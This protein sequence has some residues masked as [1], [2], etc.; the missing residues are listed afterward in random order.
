MDTALVTCGYPPQSGLGA[1]RRLWT[2]MPLP[3]GAT[4][5][6][7]ACG[8]CHTA[9]ICEDGT[10]YWCINNL[11]NQLAEPE[12]TD[13]YSWTPAPLPAGATPTKLVCGNNHMAALC[14]D[15]T[16][17]VFGCNA[18]G[19]LGLGDT[20]RDTKRS[21][22]PAPLPAGAKPTHLAC[23]GE[24]TAALCEDGTLFVCG[25][26]YHGQLGLGDT[27]GRPSWTPTPLPVGAKPMQ[28]SCGG[29][30]TAALCEDGRL[31]VCGS[32]VFGQLG[33][34]KYTV[35]W[36][37]WTLAPLPTG[38]APTQIACGV[39][40]TAALCEDGTLYV[41]GINEN[42]QLGLG[43]RSSRVLYSWTPAPPPAGAKPTY[44]ACGLAH[45]AA[46]CEDGT[47]YVCGANDEGQLGLGDT[48]DRSSWTPAPLPAGAKPTH[49]ACGDHHTAAFSGLAGRSWS[50]QI[51]RHFPRA[52]RRAALMLLCNARRGAP[53]HLA[54]GGIGALP[55]ELW[56]EI[57]R[58]CRPRDW[59]A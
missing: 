6:H 27:K 53:G 10:L 20:K 43:D 46:L 4:P 32:N 15:G 37:L 33:L 31:Y 38:A 59:R 17:Y 1:E 13:R 56:P 54:D 41:C 2:V 23:G 16:L 34:G 40:H 12:L 19:Q 55:M 25:H 29:N 42:G 28:L 39:H 21:W 36:S 3:G 30:H 8:H 26:N 52:F 18:F 7:L 45:T 50:P 47:L 57:L 48:T 58:F 51:H 24:H 44:L 11:G 9:A 35:R 49:L 22:T 14:E 5:T